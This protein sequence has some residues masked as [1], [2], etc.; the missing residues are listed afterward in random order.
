[1]LMTLFAQPAVTQ[2]LMGTL[3]TGHLQ[4][5]VAAFRAAEAAFHGDGRV[6]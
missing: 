2:I 6:R 3:N 5:N 4:H 1:M